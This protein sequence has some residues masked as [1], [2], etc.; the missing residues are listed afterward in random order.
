MID[1]DAKDHLEGVPVGTS[2]ATPRKASSSRYTNAT[3][4]KGS[5]SV[6]GYYGAGAGITR[7][8]KRSPGQLKFDIEVTKYIVNGNLSFN[9]VRSRAFK[10]FCGNTLLRTF[11]IKNPTTYSKAKVPLLYRQVKAAVNLQ[12]KHDLPHTTGFAFSADAW[13]SR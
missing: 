6:A 4:A 5:P 10:D 9:H 3:P 13:T 1:N 7:V 2:N 8:G 11:W 12:I